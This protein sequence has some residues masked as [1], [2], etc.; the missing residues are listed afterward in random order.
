MECRITTDLSISVV[1]LVRLSPAH[2]RML[3]QRILDGLVF[4]DESAF[5]QPSM[6]VSEICPG[7]ITLSD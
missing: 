7:E 1:T 6:D 2:C 4:S 5:D 3:C